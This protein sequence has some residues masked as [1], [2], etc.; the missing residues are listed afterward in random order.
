M[1]GRDF[2]RNLGADDGATTRPENKRSINLL[3]RL[4]YRRVNHWPVVISFA[5]GD[6]VYRRSATAG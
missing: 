3:R 4:G 1:R 2:L 6:V 5:D